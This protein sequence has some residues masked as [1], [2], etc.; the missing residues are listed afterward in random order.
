MWLISSKARLP[1]RASLSFLDNLGIKIYM[2]SSGARARNPYTLRQAR[3]CPS[4]GQISALLAQIILSPSPVYHF[5]EHAIPQVWV[6]MFTVVERVR[7][8]TIRAKKAARL[9]CLFN[10]DFGVFS[11]TGLESS[12]ISEHAPAMMLQ[13]L[14]DMAHRSRTSSLHLASGTHIYVP[15]SRD[16]PN[17]S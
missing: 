12:F 3:I 6:L 4:S 5:K 17:G 10:I 1:L 13:E 16:R 11:L 9:V 14:T 7:Q 2:V 15:A 8:G